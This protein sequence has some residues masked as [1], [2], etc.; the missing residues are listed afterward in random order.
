MSEC[1]Y[2]DWMSIDVGYGESW[3]VAVTVKCNTDGTLEVVDYANTT[4]T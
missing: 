4:T 1:I 3:G 2:V